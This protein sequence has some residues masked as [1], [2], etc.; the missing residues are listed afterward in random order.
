M[1]YRLWEIQYAGSPKILWSEIKPTPAQLAIATKLGLQVSADD[2]FAVVASNILEVVGHA[3]GCPGRDVSDRQRKLAE[4]LGIDIT[5]CSSSPVAF[6]RIQQAIRIANWDAARRMKLKPG[7][8][9]VVN[10]AIRVERDLRESVGERWESV[11]SQPQRDDQVSRIREDGQVFFTG[12]GQAPARYLTKVAAP[13]C[14][15]KES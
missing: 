5:D 4:E 10:R 3:I 2:T 1:N 11:Y 14:P 6:I 15:H 8:M 7:D 9:V 12:G 13:D